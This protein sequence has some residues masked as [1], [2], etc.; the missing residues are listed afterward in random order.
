IR[1][2]EVAEHSDR[3]RGIGF[4]FKRGAADV[5]IGDKINRIDAEGFVVLIHQQHI[6]TS[7][8]GIDGYHYRID[9]YAGFEIAVGFIDKQFII[10]GQDIDVLAIHGLNHIDRR[11]G[12]L[13]L[14]GFVEQKLR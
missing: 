8:I 10:V 6:F 7:G 4:T 5:D 3:N 2:F 9:I 14:P 13:P 12:Q 1:S 11:I